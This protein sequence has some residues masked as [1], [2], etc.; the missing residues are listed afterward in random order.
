M[1]RNAYARWNLRL[2][3]TAACGMAVAVLFST[4]ASV[5]AQVKGPAE[6]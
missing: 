2:L 5:R 1:I 3:S 4:A 6:D